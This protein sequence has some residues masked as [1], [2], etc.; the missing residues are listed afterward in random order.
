MIGLFVALLAG[1]PLWLGPP[2]ASSP[3]AR[4]VSLAPSLTE[5]VC[6]LDACERLVGVTRF[7]DT[8]AS[9]QR[10]PKIGG[11]V[12][13][14]VEAVAALH[15][16]LVVAMAT[17]GGRATVETL[18]RLG[19]TVLVLPCESLADVWAALDTLGRTLGNREA[20]ARE[21]KRLHTA[22]DATS[23]SD[24]PRTVVVVGHKPLVVAGPGTFLQALVTLAGGRNAVA[25]GP[26][27]PTVDLEALMRLDPD[28]VIDVSG[29]AGHGFWERFP[30]LRAV[31]DRRVVRVSSP[32]VVRP[33]PRL[34]EG[35]RQLRAA[36]HHG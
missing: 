15:P 5:F 9:V 4:I 29:D 34:D 12:D 23:V 30:A 10:L 33:G 26:A 28:V 6:A 16:D 25:A 35:L 18:G 3:P 17:Q 2:A 11:F 7:D 8:P 27:Y 24:G 20:A 21:A 14:S 1:A 32:A 36:M 22:L 31:R 19:L 13:V